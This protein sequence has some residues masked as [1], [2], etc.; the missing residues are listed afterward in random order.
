M[1]VVSIGIAIASTIIL[2]KCQPVEKM[3]KDTSVFEVP[4]KNNLNA[5][6]KVDTSNCALLYLMLNQPCVLTTSRLTTKNLKSIEIWIPPENPG[7]NCAMFSLQDKEVILRFGEVDIQMNTKRKPKK[8]EPIRTFLLANYEYSNSMKTIE[9]MYYPAG[10][11]Y[12][13]VVRIENDKAQIKDFFC[14]S[15]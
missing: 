6:L 3:K 11:V 9:L 15:I 4:S 12:K 2:F 5:S 13:L 8:A 14:Y 10:S 7:F 1:R